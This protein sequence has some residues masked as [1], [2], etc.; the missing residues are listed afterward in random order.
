[1]LRGA[2]VAFKDFP[3]PCEESAAYRE[4]VYPS[5]PLPINTLSFCSGILDQEGEMSARTS[6][7]RNIGMS[8]MKWPRIILWDSMRLCPASGSNV[9]VSPLKLLESVV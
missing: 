9:D 5:V 8:E 7:C 4:I 1:M 6:L 2:L 3:H